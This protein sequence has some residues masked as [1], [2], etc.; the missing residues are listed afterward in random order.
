[1]LIHTSSEDDCEYFWSNNPSNILP[2]TTWNIALQFLYQVRVI[3]ERKNY[4]FFGNFANIDFQF[5]R[6]K[7]IH[8]GQQ[9]MWIYLHT[10]N[11]NDVIPHINIILISNH[12]LG[13]L[14]DVIELRFCFDELTRYFTRL[15][16]FRMYR[17]VGSRYINCYII[18]PMF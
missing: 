4:L 10:I 18:L 13:S 6:S 12:L 8:E 11:K 1:M 17:L 5:I 14:N 15:L 16:F 9:I 3:F 7:C 2:P